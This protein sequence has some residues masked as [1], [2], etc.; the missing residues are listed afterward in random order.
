MGKLIRFVFV[1]AL[2]MFLGFILHDPIDVK[3]KDWFGTQRVEKLEIIA[4]DGF[5]KSVEKVE[6]RKEA[7]KIEKEQE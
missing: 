1:L 2:G 4:E 5:E 7:K 3:V 6:A